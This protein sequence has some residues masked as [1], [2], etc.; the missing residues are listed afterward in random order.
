MTN[1]MPL[2]NE[3][4]E[5]QKRQEEIARKQHVK[6]LLEYANRVITLVRNKSAKSK[7]AKIETAIKERLLKQDMAVMS[8]VTNHSDPWAQVLPTPKWLACQESDGTY[9]VQ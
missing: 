8:G 2:A 3:V 9:N 7:D 1:P 4:A 5:F 6:L